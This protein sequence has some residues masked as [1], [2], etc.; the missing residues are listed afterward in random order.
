MS[1]GFISVSYIMLHLER[2][3]R[4]RCL[5]DAGSIKSL[6]M[7]QKSPHGHVAVL[8]LNHHLNPVTLMFGASE[9]PQ[10][11]EPVP[12][13]LLLFLRTLTPVFGALEIIM[14]EFNAK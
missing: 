4:S 8:A 10:T 7:H 12:H 1:H 13:V 6:N 14:K 5:W 3:R 2:K 11:N 9:T